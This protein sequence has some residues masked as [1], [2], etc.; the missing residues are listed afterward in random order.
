MA[1]NGLVYKR[2]DTPIKSRFRKVQGVPSAYEFR[3]I[4]DD[5]GKTRRSELGRGGFGAVYLV[6]DKKTHAQ[7]AWKEFHNNETKG[8]LS[9][10][11]HM[12]ADLVREIQS[13]FRGDAW[14]ESHIPHLRDAFYMEDDEGR[15]CFVQVTDLIKGLPLKECL[16][17]FN[18]DSAHEK[19]E[20]LSLPQKARLVQALFK[21]VAKLHATD[22][23]HRDIK[24]ANI[25]IRNIAAPAGLEAAD[26]DNDFVLIDFGLACKKSDNVTNHVGTLAF[27]APELLS[28]GVIKDILAPDVWAAGVTAYAIMNNSRLPFSLGSSE[29]ISKMPREQK[30]TL[31]LEVIDNRARDI[32]QRSRPFS[33]SGDPD[34]DHFLTAMLIGTADDSRAI[35]AT[36]PVHRATMN[37]ALE[38]WTEKVMPKY[39]ARAPAEPVC[40]NVASV[41][42]I[43]FNN[44]DS[45]YCVKRAGKDHFIWNRRAKTKNCACVFTDV[46]ALHQKL[47]AAAPQRKN[48]CPHCAIIK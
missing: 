35:S 13:A 5:Q 11:G 2:G 31:L 3:Q 22:I 40:P 7:F 25:M 24:P 30:R 33:R 37:E 43:L 26:F 16:S 17:H 4:T 15:T 12:E 1:T 18:V 14:M 8:D 42:R 38:I 36:N 41:A 23:A 9:T 45:E 34:A 27:E 32:L 6:R 46:G 20:P 44:S 21:T 28:N 48:V 39:A 47:C 10:R 19:A 29:S